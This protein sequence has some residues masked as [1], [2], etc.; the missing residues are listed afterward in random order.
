MSGNYHLYLPAHLVINSKHERCFHPS[1]TFPPSPLWRYVICM[2]LRETINLR[3]FFLLIILTHSLEEF[4]N[5][6]PKVWKAQRKISTAA[7]ELR[8]EL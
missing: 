7:E 5:R 2:F 3:C 8:L 1:R 6:Y 4:E